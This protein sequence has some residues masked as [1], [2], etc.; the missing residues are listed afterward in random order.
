MYISGWVYVSECV[1]I[2]L[3]FLVI[4]KATRWSQN[5]NHRLRLQSQNILLYLFLKYPL[6]IWNIANVYVVKHNSL[7]DYLMRETKGVG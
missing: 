4:C 1:I 5:V 7:Y 2:C 6:K 3:I